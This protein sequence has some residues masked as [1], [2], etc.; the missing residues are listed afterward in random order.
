MDEEID[1]LVSREAA[2]ETHKTRDWTQG[3]I[4]KNLL[5]LSWPMVVS[6][7]INVLGPTV[8]YIW[9][10]KLGPDAM[11]AVGVSGMVVMLVNALLMGIFTGLRSMVSRYVGAKDKDGAIHV[12]Q[13]AFVVAGILGVLLAI[14]GISLDRWILGLLGYLRQYLRW[15]PHICVS[16]SSG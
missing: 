13:Q 15:A 12:T 9:L 1:S 3:S 14:I 5:S 2:R 11:A 10:G 4:I 6:N 16:I 7:S 8:D